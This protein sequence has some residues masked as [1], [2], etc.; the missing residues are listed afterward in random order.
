M[1][2]RCAEQGLLCQYCAGTGAAR[3]VVTAW[4][5]R[6]SLPGRHSWLAN[7]YRLFFYCEDYT[8]DIVEKLYRIC[9]S[10]SQ[11]C[12]FSMKDEDLGLL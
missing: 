10:V 1:F 9:S 8:E 2:K 3:L 11:H 4:A 5:W 12:P 6:G 7:L